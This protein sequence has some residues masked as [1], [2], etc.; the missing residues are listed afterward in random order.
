MH[1]REGLGNLVK[2]LDLTGG[3]GSPWSLHALTDLSFEQASG[4]HE[5]GMVAEG[6]GGSNKIRR[7][8]ANISD[9]QYPPQATK[10]PFK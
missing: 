2:T 4:C 9:I 1:F 3:H 5:T 7:F 8:F 6:K 10:L